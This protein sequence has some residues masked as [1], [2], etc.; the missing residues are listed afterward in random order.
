MMPTALFL[1]KETDQV[2]VVNDQANDG[3]TK[4]VLFLSYFLLFTNF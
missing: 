3:K 1:D 2:T 4:K